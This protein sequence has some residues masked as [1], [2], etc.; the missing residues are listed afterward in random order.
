M[1]PATNL[2]TTI[3]PDYD[4][5][6]RRQQ[7]TWATGDFGRIGAQMQIVGESLCEALDL[8]P[9]ERVLDVAAGSGNASLAAARRYADVTST[10][11]VPELLEQG[12]RRAAAEGLP[13]ETRVADAEN[14][15]FED[16]AFDVALSTYGVMFAPNQRRAASELLRVVKAG[17]RIGLA[18]WTPDGMIGELFKLIG[19]FVAPPAG[20]DS[21]SA[22]GTEPRLVELF[23]PRASDIRTQRKPYVFRFRSAEHWIDVFRTYYGP[24]NKAFAALDAAKQHELHA[25][26]VELLGRYDRGAGDGLVTPADY[27]EVVITKAAG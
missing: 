11:Y 13:M 7:A 8:R 18:N 21:P 23:G 15:P 4:A 6:K 3:T 2:P 25:A 26:L 12:R 22:W 9:S 1:Q 19:R 14:L 27:L 5:I 10:D 24:V 16:G 20:L 17:G